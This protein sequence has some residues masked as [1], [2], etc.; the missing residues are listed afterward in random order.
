VNSESLIVDLPLYSSKKNTP[1]PKGG[2]N[3]NGFIRRFAAGGVDMIV[4][5]EY[6][7]PI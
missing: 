5:K 1:R 4:V 7:Y 2:E 6:I 3:H